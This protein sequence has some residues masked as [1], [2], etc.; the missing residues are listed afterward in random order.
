MKSVEEVRKAI[1]LLRK[2][3]AVSCTCGSRLCAVVKK[4]TLDQ[5]DFGAWI[6]G[7]NDSFDSKIE[8][9]IQ[10]MAK[11]DAIPTRR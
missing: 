6:I 4:M 7:D 10:N 3:A 8:Y 11:L 9:L 1:A 5:A 2:F